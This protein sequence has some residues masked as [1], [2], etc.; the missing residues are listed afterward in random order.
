MSLITTKSISLAVA[1]EIASL[2]I[3][4]AKSQGFNP[5]SICVMDPSG[6]EIV[7]KRMDGCPHIAYPKISR[8]KA[9]TCVAVKS[10]SRAYGAKYLMGKDGIS[11]VGPEVFARV[12]NQINTMDGNM[13]AFQG[14]VLIREKDSGIIV[15]SVGVSGAAGDEDEFCALTGVKEC[16]LADQLVTE[17]LEHSCK[18]VS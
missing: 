11:P 14:G 18:T 9:N 8:A 6:A 13:A 17:P 1:D 10:S 4:A 15:G 5:I 12:L 2:A 16:N 7:T 3:K